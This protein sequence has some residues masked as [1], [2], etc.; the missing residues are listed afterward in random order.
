M[1]AFTPSTVTAIITADGITHTP[2]AGSVVFEHSNGSGA[3]YAV[4]MLKWVET[5]AV[6]RAPVASVALLSF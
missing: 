1:F 5:A 4:P 2:N 3:Y 6:K